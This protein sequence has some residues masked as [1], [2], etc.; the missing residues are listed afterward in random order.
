MMQ[1]TIDLAGAPGD[2]WRFFEVLFHCLPRVSTV[3]EL[4]A[5]LE[6]LPSTL[7]SRFFRAHLP[8][9]KRYLIM[10][11]LT[12]AASLFENPG[13]SVANVSNQ[14]DYSSPQSFGRHIRT[15]LHITAVDFRT[16]YDGEGMLRR[17]REELVL[18][19]LA[20]FRGFTP[21]TGPPG[22]IPPSGS[23][24]RGSGRLRTD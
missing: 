19:Y 2:C 12:R 18:P 13:L 3:R 4:S 14:L 1:L 20:T 23:Q 15:A 10:A 16:R 9:P 8:A 11:R 21:L 22:W 7:M 5:K 6:V 17:F 24:T